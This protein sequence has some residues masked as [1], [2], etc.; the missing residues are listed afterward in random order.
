M[1]TALTLDTHSGYFYRNGER[2]IPVGVN[3]WP[4][5]CGIEMWPRWPADEIRHDLDV[6]KRLSLNCL[7]FFLRWQDFEPEPGVYDATMF[8]RLEQMLSWCAERGLYA[9]PSL[10]VG[11]MSGGTFWPAWR[12]GRNVFADPFMV[13][14]AVAFAAKAASVIAPFYPHLAGVDQGNELCCLADSRQAPPDAVIHWCGAVSAAIR[15]AYPQALIVSGNEQG[16]INSDSGWQLGNQP[17]T[18]FYSMHGY[19]VPSWH[20]ISFDGMTDPLCQSLLPFYTRIAR[21]YGPVMLQEFGTIITFGAAQQDAYLRAILPACWDSGANGFLWWCLRDIH[22]SIHPYVKNNFESTLGLI[23]AQDR[24]KPGLEYYLEFARSL[25]QRPAPTVPEDAVGVYIPRHYYLRDRQENPGNDPAILS[26]RLI[27]ANYMLQQLGHPVRVVRGDRPLP[28]D[29]RCIVVPGAMLDAVEAKA[30]I[31]WVDAGGRLVWHGPDPVNWGHTYIR[32]LGARPVDYRAS[33]PMQV[34]AF[35]R[36]WSY[37]RYPRNMRVQIEP[38]IARVIADD[39]DGLPAIL[40]HSLG[41]GVVAYT[42]PVVEDAMAATS[43]RRDLRP[44]WLDW[45]RGML[46]LVG[47]S[48]R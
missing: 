9:Q 26:R 13:E 29:V 5:S 8:E 17:G 25:P 40:C 24:V 18:D 2:F 45:Y 42:L 3:Y 41:R 20:N 37:D 14:R 36:N 31:D 6:I 11:W 27:I 38:D 19:P 7:R 46:E 44:L 35:G 48:S 32:L 22:A 47:V 12:E 33:R 28:D 21:A 34:E 39:Q 15:S 4:A 23:D 43:D 10:F 1:T 30:M 16:Q